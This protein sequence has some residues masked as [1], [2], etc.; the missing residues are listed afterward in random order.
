MCDNKAKRWCFTLNNPT[1]EDI[2]DWIGTESDGPQKLNKKWLTF[3]RFQLEKGEKEGTYHW[4]GFL[5][6]NDRKRLSWL[7]ANISERAHW[8]VARG[9]N[10][11]CYNYCS[12]EETRVGGDEGFEY[13]WGKMPEKATVK[14]AAERLAD[15]CEELDVVKEGYKRPAEIPS[16]T[17]MQQGFL[18]AY[19]ELT[20]DCLGPYRP[21]LFILTMVGPPGTGK[22]YAI[23]KHWPD[24]GACI[25]GNGGIW[26]QNAMANVMVFEEFS[27]QIPLHRMLKFLDP[28]PLALEVKG[29]MR[30]A[31]YN[32]VIIT[33]NTP[34]CEWYQ[35][36]L[37][38]GE[39]R[40]R[41]QDAIHALWDRLGYNH[42][43]YV[44]VRSC[45]NYCEAPSREGMFCRNGYEW[46]EQCRKDFEHICDAIVANDKDD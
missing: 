40:N 31:M 7:K 46:L 10:E 8:E 6:L 13:E 2:L 4:Q 42:G 12:K 18:P 23:Q 19:K 29:G 37:G 38:E 45:G 27:G 32:M 39:E 20:C 35:N 26:F 33:S 9:T 3:I 22:S 25:Y 36:T 34:P 15:A 28:Y 14:K 43:D 1:G 5:I 21:D 16:V 11:Q 17:L 41:R 44:C 24:H 30:P